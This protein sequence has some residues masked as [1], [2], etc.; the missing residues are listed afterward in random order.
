MRHQLLKLGTRHSTKAERRFSELLKE[1]RIPFQTK[2]KIN[3]REVDFLIGEY[4]IDIDG[5]PQDVYKNRMLMSLG[6]NPIHLTNKFNIIATKEWLKIIC[7]QE[8]DY[9]HQ[10]VQQSQ[11]H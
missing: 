5:H 2:V 3:N 6:Y 7:Q 8:Q 1:L 11:S 10:Q 4:A 9:S